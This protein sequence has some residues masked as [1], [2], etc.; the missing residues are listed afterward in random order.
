MQN[1][2][3]VYFDYTCRYSY[4]AVHWL[5]QIP[6]A[7]IEWRTFSLKEVNREPD[8]PSWLE[9]NAPPSLSV[10]AL[11]LGH[12]A[13]E[14]DFDR[15]HHAVFEAMHGEERHLEEH[16]FL[17]LAAEAGVDVDAFSADRGSWVGRVGA[18]HRDAV[19]G[20]GVYGTPTV[21]LDGMAAYV[22]LTDVPDSAEVA[23]RILNGLDGIASSPANLVEIFLP[24]EP[25]SP[26]PVQIGQ[27][28]PR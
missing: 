3:P 13:R 10:L 22:R 14:A 11:A 17:A 24:P 5:D 23:A 15:F 9:P 12:A 2:L 8:E 26:A 20:L 19:T 7:K 27:R 16:E 1:A 6:G 18:E 21:V 28:T 4:R 25:P